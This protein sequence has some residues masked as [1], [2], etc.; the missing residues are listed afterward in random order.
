MSTTFQIFNENKEAI[1]KPRT[2]I[3]LYGCLETLMDL[4]DQGRNPRYVKITGP[5]QKNKDEW[6]KLIDSLGVLDV[7][8]GVV[9]RHRGIYTQMFYDLYQIS[10]DQFLFCHTLFRYGWEQKSAKN[11]T[12]H[13]WNKGYSAIDSLILGHFAWHIWDNRY[14]KF[15][16]IPRYLG[17]DSQ[18][19]AGHCLSMEIWIPRSVIKDWETWITKDQ[20]P[21]S[22]YYFSLEEA[23]KL[24][25]SRFPICRWINSSLPDEHFPEDYVLDIFNN[26][27]VCDV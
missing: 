13:W 4:H 23:K 22:E 19:Y 10:Y 16:Q 1:I 11:N 26:L 18:P 9:I 17:F 21:F 14:I 8:P 5:W 27:E 2:R 6:R 20:Y 25:I 12:L 15:T 3:C 24:R 7:L